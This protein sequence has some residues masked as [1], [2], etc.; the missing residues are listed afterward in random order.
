ME[1]EI[2]NHLYVLIL[3]GGGGNRLWPASR[4]KTPKQFL[5]NFF[6]QTSLFTQTV[7]RAQWL[8]SNEKIFVVTLNDY[9]D[10]VLNQGKVI[11]PRNVISEPQGKNTA[12]AM[13]IGAAYIKKIDPRAIIINFASDHIIGD[14]E[15]FVSQ[16][17]LA[18][19]AAASGNYLIAVGI[20][21]RFAHSGLGY[22]EAGKKFEQISDKVFKVVSF[23]EKPDLKTAKRFLKSGRYFWNANLY[24]WSAESIWSAFFKYAPKTFFLLEEVF[25]HIGSNNEAKILEKVYRE[26]ESVQIDYAISEKA[27]NLLLVPATFSWSDIG[28]WKTAYEIKKKDKNGNVV[29]YYGE[30]GFFLGTETKNCFIRAEDSL[31][32]TVGV[33]DLIIVQMRDAVLVCSRDKAQKVKEIVNMLKEEKKANLL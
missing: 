11:L 14:K 19:Q 26:A 25:K 15:K 24:V 23:K 13:G 32:A 20:K 6:G 21:P 17:S 18:V 9:V 3:C 12:L 2:K 27:D 10:E 4:Q 29:E 31:V 33:S 22:I 5:R 28:D 8:T 1:E 30:N 16:I 7:E